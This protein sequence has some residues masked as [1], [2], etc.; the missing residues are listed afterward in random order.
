MNGSMTDTV[1]PDSLGIAVP[2]EWVEVPVDRRQFDE[3]ASALR[4]GWVD[5]GWDRTTQRRAELLL[6]RIRRDILRAGIQFIAVY[7]DEPTDE[8]R[9]AASPLPGEEPSA[10]EREIVMS[11]VTVGTY[12]KDQLG[13]KANL[14]VGNLL[15]SM[16]RKSERDPSHRDAPD[17]PR[18]KRIVDLQP[19]VVHRMPIGRSVRLRRLY[20]LLTPGV[21]PQ[22]FYGESYLAPIGDTGDECVIAHFTTINL[23]LTS[24]FS[25]LFETIAGTITTW[26]PDEP[27]S[28]ESEWVESSDG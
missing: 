17:A 3:F 10:E 28:F 4:T 6:A 23:G 8:D 7:I 20:E 19:P 21:L 13:A 25:E 26:T 18:Y 12:T 1:R 5:H 11:T 27:T 15:V 16:S 2:S 24:V 14:T 9:A 22:R